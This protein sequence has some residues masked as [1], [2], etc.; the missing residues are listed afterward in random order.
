MRTIKV[1]KLTE[2]DFREYGSFYDMTNPS[3]HTLG[4]FYNDYVLMPVS[5]DHPIGFS[6]L[7]AKKAEKMIIDSAEFHDT[8]SEIQLPLDD[9][10][11]IHVAPPSNERVPE[12]TQAFYIPKG[13]IVLLNCGV[14]HLAPFAV[15][16]ETAHVLVALPERIYHNDCTVVTYKTD[17]MME[18][19][20]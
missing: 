11:I 5:G 4:T 18:I 7:I 1:K 15:H 3:G 16:N 8:T 2:K 10:I 12:L 14:W 6:T 20:L 17:E 13:T 9:D 19:V